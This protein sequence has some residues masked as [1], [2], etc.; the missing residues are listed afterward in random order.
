MSGGRGR[1]TVLYRLSCRW[2]CT[3]ISN[4]LWLR[5]LPPRQQSQEG[6]RVASLRRPRLLVSTGRHRE[7]RV[8]VHGHHHE[9]VHDGEHHEYP[10]RHEVPVPCPDVAAEHRAEQAELHRLPDR[11]PRQHEHEADDR[12][13]EVRAALERV[14]LALPR[15][16]LPDEQ[17]ELHHLPRVAEMSTP[18]HEV[19]PLTV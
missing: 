11:E 5:P 2:T 18:R 13:R 4:R 15:V 6:P 3:E 1:P 14:V 8:R 16:I 10:R 9:Y 7:H 19:A 12:H 17:I